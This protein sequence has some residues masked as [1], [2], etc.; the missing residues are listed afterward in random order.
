VVGVVVLAILFGMLG[1]LVPLWV[2]VHLGHKKGQTT[3]GWLLGI[4]LGCA[5][6]LIM[7]IIAPSPE[8][9]RRMDLKHGFPCPFCQEPVK[10]GATVCPHCQRS[11]P[12]P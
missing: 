3:A 5:G 9:Q 12:A 8:A 6:T 2:S 10:R 4:F 7:T 11:L 1:W